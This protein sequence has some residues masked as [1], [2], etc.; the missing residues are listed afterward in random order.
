MNGRSRSVARGVNAGDASRRRQ[1]G[2][3]HRQDRP[4]LA[5][6]QTDGLDAR[7]LR[8]QRERR[9]EAALP[10][11]GHDVLVTGDGAAQGGAVR[12]CSWARAASNRARASAR[13]IPSASTSGRSSSWTGVVVMAGR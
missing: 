8:Q 11:H 4:G 2:T 1:L 9:V 10:Q 6:L 13:S 12:P 3:L 5:L 7:H